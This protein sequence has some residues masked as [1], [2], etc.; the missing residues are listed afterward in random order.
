MI[1]FASFVITVSSLISSCYFYT[2]ILQKS[3]SELE[4]KILFLE[5]Q[6]KEQ[7]QAL[8]DAQ[9]SIDAQTLIN[10]TQVFNLIGHLNDPATIKLIL[11]L[12]IIIFLCGTS[13]YFISSIIASTVTFTTGVQ[14]TCN[15]FLGTPNP[16]C[17]VFKMDTGLVIRVIKEKGIYLL[18]YLDVNSVEYKPI[19]HFLKNHDKL[20][21]LLNKSTEAA[22]AD[23]VLIAGQA[24]LEAL[25]RLATGT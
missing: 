5:S 2:S 13:Y 25:F 24:N 22:L 15:F 8:I 19:E 6:L 17:I 3:I 7:K 23:P 4:A 10:D 21:H 18:Q 16:T 20:V 1:Q 14:D 9:A 11:T 12:I